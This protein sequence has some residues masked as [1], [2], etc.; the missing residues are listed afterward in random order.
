MVEAGGGTLKEHE[1]Q[2]GRGSDVD[3]AEDESCGE[4]Y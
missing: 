1:K 4:E 3:S 2:R